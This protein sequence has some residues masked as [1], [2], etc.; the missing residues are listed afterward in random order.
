MG[1]IFRACLLTIALFVLVPAVPASGPSCAAP[2][3]AT[4]VPLPEGQYARVAHEGDSDY[5]QLWRE[6]NGIPGLQPS[7]FRCMAGDSWRGDDLRASVPL[8]GNGGL[9]A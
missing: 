3:D 8:S 4:A 1:T 5:A 9:D 2:S 7:G 6:D